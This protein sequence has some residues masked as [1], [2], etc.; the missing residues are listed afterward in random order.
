MR[1]GFFAAVLA[2]TQLA[3]AVRLDP[4]MMGGPSPMGGMM[5][6][7][8]PSM[9]GMPGGPPPM[10]GGMG[11]MGGSPGGMAKLGG[12]AQQ[13]GGNGDY[14]DV[15]YHSNAPMPMLGGGMGQMAQ[16]G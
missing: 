13:G 15:H 3:Y 2:A 14:I 4:G 10:G 11:P 8:P 12:G 16:G 5:G 9:G 7:P 1:F 6:G